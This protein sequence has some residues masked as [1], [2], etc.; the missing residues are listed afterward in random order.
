MK[1]S[2]KIEAGGPSGFGAL[3]AT[4][5]QKGGSC[6]QVAQKLKI[7]FVRG[8][9]AL[10]GIVVTGL[11]LLQT[12]MVGMICKTNCLPSTSAT[13][14]HRTDAQPAIHHHHSKTTSESD[15]SSSSCCSDGFTLGAGRC[16]L[17]Y[18]L[19]P[20]AT[21]GR[22]SHFAATSSTYAAST[23]A[24]SGRSL[25]PEMPIFDSSPPSAPLVTRALETA[26]RI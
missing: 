16:S 7:R 6:A 2:Y 1:Q 21:S 3:D 4:T 14:A 22:T 8:R 26:L 11:L 23:Y 25:A 12:G 20:A 18:E 17:R 24:A 13:H 10:T 15:I 5:S 19:T 9:S